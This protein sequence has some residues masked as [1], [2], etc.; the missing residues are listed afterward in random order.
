MVT[1]FTCTLLIALLTFMY[2]EVSNENFELL[3][4]CSSLSLAGSYINLV[5]RAGYLLI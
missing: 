1:L 5:L 2:L 3:L 4:G